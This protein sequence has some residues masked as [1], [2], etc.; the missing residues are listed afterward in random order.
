MQL[1]TEGPEL[2]TL[3][4]VSAYQFL[5]IASSGYGFDSLSLHFS[6]QST[7]IGKAMGLFGVTTI[8][9]SANTWLGEFKN[10]KA[11]ASYTAWGVYNWTS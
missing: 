5:C 6:Q 4:T 3:T 10:W 8:T 1:A 9:E 7:V 11:F 2:L